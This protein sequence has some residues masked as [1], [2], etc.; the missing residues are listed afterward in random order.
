M[1]GGCENRDAR[2]SRDVILMIEDER[3]MCCFASVTIQDGGSYKCEASQH[4]RPAHYY[5]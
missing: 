1:M 2:K 5:E 4:P 3:K